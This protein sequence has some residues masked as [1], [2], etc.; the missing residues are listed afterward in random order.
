MSAT[1]VSV[2]AATRPVPAEPAGG[3]VAFAKLPLG[4]RKLLAAL[5]EREWYR[6]RSFVVESNEVGELV[7]L[8]PQANRAME[9]CPARMIHR[10]RT[11]EI[12][13]QQV[14]EVY[15]GLHDAIHGVRQA[16]HQI[17]RLAGL[18][19]TKPRIS[20]EAPDPEEPPGED[21]PAPLGP[22]AP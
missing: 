20:R 2:P 21:V 10:I 14:D 4:L 22:E 6:I 9:K 15:N 19:P 18:Q 7:E 3:E 17:F 13:G 8:I 1:E 12:T 5:P 11:K 16:V